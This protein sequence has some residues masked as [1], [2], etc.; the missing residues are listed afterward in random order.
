[1]I[2]IR[3]HKQGR[4][5]CFA[6]PYGGGFGFQNRRGCG[7][8]WGPGGPWAG[9]GVPLGGKKCRRE[10]KW[11]NKAK[12]GDFEF[13]EKKAEKFAN[14]MAAAFGLDPEVA[15][16]HV[17]EIVAEMRKQ[18]NEM[19]KE[20]GK[21]GESKMET[22]EQEQQKPESSTENQP[23][24]QEAEQTNPPQKVEDIMA[25][26]GRSLGMNPEMF[27]Q[28]VESLMRAST[29][30]GEQGSVDQAIHENPY[31]ALNLM[32]QQ[33]F[34]E[35]T[36]RERSQASS[37]VDSDS[38]STSSQGQQADESSHMKS[39]SPTQ[40]RVRNGNLFKVYSRLSEQPNFT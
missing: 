12:K 8:P 32:M 26:F 13:Y 23:E 18:C 34:K 2:C 10:E 36:E 39:G 35:R 22:D 33:L 5:Q 30:P 6:F 28:G 21:E 40:S 15:Q 1:M 4:P 7:G 31:A 29:Q 14:R 17:K 16:S 9:P 24:P 19:Q 38:L 25:D 11:A 20:N 3:K 37:A 27:T